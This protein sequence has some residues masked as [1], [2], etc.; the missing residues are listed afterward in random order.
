LT[1]ILFHFW[2]ALALS[3]TSG[4]FFL[5]EVFSTFWRPFLI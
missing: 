3:L 4:I 1:Q 2:L 5:F